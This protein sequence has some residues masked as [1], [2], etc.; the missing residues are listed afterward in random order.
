MA[1]VTEGEEIGFRAGK[2]SIWLG[3]ISKLEKELEILQE[4]VQEVLA[5]NIELEVSFT[6]GQQE[7]WVGN[8]FT[9]NPSATFNPFMLTVFTSGT[10][11]EPKK[12]QV[13]LRTRVRKV[14]ELSQRKWLLC[15]PLGRWASF[16]LILHSVVNR[17]T[18]VSPR[19]FD[20]E[21]VLRAMI[22]S[23]AN[24]ISLTP[25]FFKSLILS[26]Q[27][28]LSKLPIIS[29]T[30]GGEHVS[31]SVLDLAKK[32]WPAAAVTHVYASTEFGEILSENDGLEGFQLSQ[33]E[34][35]N[36]SLD[37]DG[38]L[39]VAGKP[40]GD[41]WK[42]VDKRIHFLGRDSE[43]VNVGGFNVSLIKVER[44]LESVEGVINARVTTSKSLLVGELL[45]A[46]VV[47]NVTSLEIRRALS[48][49]LPKHEI[50][51]EISIV[52]ELSLS[53]SMKSKRR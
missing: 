10:T 13:D 33:L 12:I 11:G 1:Q 15:Y 31:Q 19:S 30:F 26:K 38:Q 27:E 48:K 44:A 17:E 46:Q 37:S 29:I 2:Y 6:S 28:Q 8:V 34:R 41:Y 7:N 49:I 25:S 3:D 20:P 52:K 23:G 24:S 18:L 39:I 35:K 5:G 42:I 4:L 50:P 9:Q 47:G 43:I 45:M 40:T 51:S 36:V 22:T 14:F 53:D 21:D 32:F 16:A